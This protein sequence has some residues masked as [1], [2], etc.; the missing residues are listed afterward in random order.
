MKRT[1]TPRS[2]LHRCSLGSQ[3]IL[4]PPASPRGDDP[5]VVRYGL[6][7]GEAWGE[8]FFELHYAGHVA[9]AVAVVWRRPDRYYVFVFEVVLGVSVGGC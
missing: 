6:E 7:D 9:A 3:E 4:A 2:P 5:L 8:V 1:P